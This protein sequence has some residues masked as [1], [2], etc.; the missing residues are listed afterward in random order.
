MTNAVTEAI[1]TLLEDEWDD[2]PRGINQ[3]E[4]IE[5][6]NDLLLEDD[7]DIERRTTEDLPDIYIQQSDGENIKPE[8]YHV[9]VTDGEKHYDAEVPNGVDSW[10][11][12]PFFQRTL[13]F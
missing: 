13:G 2:N 12:L 4:C 10:E 9:W 6:A 8:P 11:K 1:N 3:G 7:L 5:F